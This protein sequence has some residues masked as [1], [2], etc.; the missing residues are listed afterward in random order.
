[1]D[2]LRCEFGNQQPAPDKAR[3]V[4]SQHGP[5]AV[6]FGEGTQQIQ[7]MF[8]AYGSVTINIRTGLLFAE[9]GASKHYPTYICAHGSMVQWFIKSPKNFAD[10][11]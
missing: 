4:A 3:A 11:P 1:M 7:Q 9:S 6:S 10:S 2:I 5:L 8:Q